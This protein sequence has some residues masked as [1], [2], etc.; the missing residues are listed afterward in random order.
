[1]NPN[2]LP[3]QITTIPAMSLHPAR[4]GNFR[5]RSPH[6]PRNPLKVWSITQWLIAVNV[7]VYAVDALT[8][9][10]LDPRFAFSVD[11]AIHHFHLWQFITFQFL[12]VGPW[13]LFYNMTALYYFGPFLEPRLRRRPYLAFYLLSGLA[14]AALYL[15]L[16]RLTLLR[17]DAGSSLIGASAGVFG[18]MVGAATLEPRRTMTLWLP[19]VTIRL[20]VLALIFVAIAAI[21]VAFSGPNAG[22]ETAHLGGAAAGFLMVRHVPWFKRSAGGKNPG[23]RF[24]HPGDP[25][26]KFFKDDLRE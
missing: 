7:A 11:G 26:S 3:P 6:A 13:H 8:R 21:V 5:N 23:Q 12:H 24:W 15:L 1:M 10:E 14:G 17:V 20:P 2:D 19:P 4:N 25:H 18:V 22:G 9:H 16:Y